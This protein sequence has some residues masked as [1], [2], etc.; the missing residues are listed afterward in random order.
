MASPIISMSFSDM[1]EAAM[2][3]ERRKRQAEND[4]L[5]ETVPLVDALLEEVSKQAVK[6]PKAEI[7]TD[8]V[9]PQAIV[10]QAINNDH[11]KQQE[12]QLTQTSDQA[13][14]AS[15]NINVNIVGTE[16]KSSLEENL[17]L[18][19]PLSGTSSQNGYA[20]QNR[21]PPVSGQTSNTTNKDELRPRPVQIEDHHAAKKVKLTKQ[22]DDTRS[23]PAISEPAINEPAISEPAIPS[24]AVPPAAPKAEDPLVT[25]ESVYLIPELV[26]PQDVAPISI[27]PEVGICNTASPN[28][29]SPKDA[30]PKVTTPITT[31]PTD[32]TIETDRLITVALYINSLQGV[33][34]PQAKT[35]GIVAR[36]EAEPSQA[37]DLSHS[38]QQEVQAAATVGQV[39]NAQ[40]PAALT[41]RA[42]S[43]LVAKKRKRPAGKLAPPAC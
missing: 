5:S 43:G 41:A 15:P 24:S 19:P 28:T 17:E 23:D 33:K 36:P 6:L 16:T 30:V 2:E 20:A 10:S 4:A 39:H 1:V 32:T 26:Y 21:A 22:E 3:E 13:S 8:I 14:D 25:P 9:G 12:G 34:Q 38:A 37:V 31:A 11:N 35:P 18:L 27:Q 29:T 42:I 40:K 7:L